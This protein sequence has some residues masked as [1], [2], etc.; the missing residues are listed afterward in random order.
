[1]ECIK[2]SAIITA[3]VG[4]IEHIGKVKSEGLAY[5]TCKAI[6]ETVGEYFKVYYK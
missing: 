6:Q 1:M 5:T 4:E 2:E 3:K